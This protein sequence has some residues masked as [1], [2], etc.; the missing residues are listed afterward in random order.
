MMGIEH[1][2]YTFVVDKGAHKAV[3]NTGLVDNDIQS[4]PGK[5]L[6]TNSNGATLKV[7]VM[8]RVTLVIKVTVV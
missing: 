5:M 1:N 3:S 8:G 6:A 2:G 7:K 4:L